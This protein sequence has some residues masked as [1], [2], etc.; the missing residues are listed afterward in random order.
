MR[1][2]AAPLA[3]VLLA[4]L[5]T[6][7]SCS[8]DSANAAVLWTDQ[9]EFAF[10][11]EMFNAGQDRYK[12]EVHYFESPAQRLTETR[13]FPDIAAASWL[14]STSTRDLFRPLDDLFR[15]ETISYSSF[16]PKLL[17]LGNIESKQYLLPVS[18]N[19]PALIFARSYGQPLS[20]PFTIDMTEIM[21]RGK[22]FNEEGSGGY[23]R[24]GFSPSWDDEFL[25]ITAALFNTGFREAAPIAWDPLALEQAMIWIQQWI[26][27]A[28]TS[29]QAEDDFAFKYLYDP[30]EKLVGEG[31]ILF[32]YMDSRKF[33]TQA[34]EHRANLDFRWIAEKEVIPLD[35]RSVYLG[36]MK[37]GRAKKAAIAFTQWFFQ[38]DTQRMLLES[39][40][41]SRLMETSFGIGGGFSGLRTVT[42]QI[43]PQFYPSLLGH[44]PPESFL[45][46]PAILPR[47]WMSIKE[48]VILPYL[49]DRI[50]S[51]SREEIRS[52]ER[53][54]TDW[55]RLNRE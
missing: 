51:Q 5:F 13:D 44:M 32:S 24:M 12:V 15:K 54:I 7:A 9:P 4:F 18:F 36:I 10:Y 25:F 46:P 26:A 49:H 41:K 35:E 3:A 47:N 30:P 45:S 38:E 42:E 29:I 39:S 1:K 34:E 52:L 23:T 11:A 55:H 6:A 21:E 31:R 33:F 14:K 22:A 37:K 27:H 53:R 19:I 28:N 8:G 17:A 48:R 2:F 20:N 16:Y 40:K 43:F 50:R